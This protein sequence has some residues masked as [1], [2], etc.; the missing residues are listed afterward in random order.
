MIARRFTTRGRT[1]LAAVMAAS[2]VAVPAVTGAQD[3]SLGTS[4]G[5]AESPAAASPAGSPAAEPSVPVNPYPEQGAIPGSGEG[6]TIGYISLGEY[7][8]FAALVTGGIQEQAEIAGANLVWCDSNTDPAKTLECAQQMATQ[9]AQGVINF[10]V[11]QAQ[12]PQYC[13]AYGNVPTIA[14]DIR[15]APCENVFYGANNHEAGRL[16]GANIGKYAKDTW[17]CDYNAYV[18]LESTGAADANTQRMGGFRDGFQEFCP[19]VNETV[20]ADADRTDKALPQMTDLLPS[21]PG[22][23]IVVVAINEDGI[24]GAIGAARTLGREADLFYAGQ[25]AD[26]SIWPEIACNP[27]YIGTVAYFPERYGRTVVPAMIDL[28]DGKEVG[29]PLYTAHEVVTAE[30]IRQIYPETA[31][32][33]AA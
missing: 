28:L 30:N 16:A 10:Q 27:Q 19:L 3:Q 33:P 31:E 9:G 14:I 20:L 1:L 22:N 17:D 4:P 24:L 21:L 11:D 6:K 15:Q 32:C 8:P 29:T 2:M 25:G 18:S 26:P 23:R 13:E 12:S 7:I 5:R